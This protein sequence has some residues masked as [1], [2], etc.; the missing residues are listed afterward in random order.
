MNINFMWDKINNET[1]ESKKTI[2]SKVLEA[3]WDIDY[4]NL[5]ESEINEKYNRL[6]TFLDKDVVARLKKFN[7]DALELV[8]HENAIEWINTELES[9]LVISNIKERTKKDS[10]QFQVANNMIYNPNEKKSA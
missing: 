9:K 7:H 3:K 5:T 10:V 1:V 2:S 4:K 8:E 6:L